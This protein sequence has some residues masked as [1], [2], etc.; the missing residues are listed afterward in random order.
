LDVSKQP[1]MDALR[2]LA[3]DG[4]VEII[5]QVGCRIP[6][7]E[8]QDVTDFFAVF[9]GQSG[10]GK[11]GRSDIG[12]ITPSGEGVGASRRSCPPTPGSGVQGSGGEVSPGRRGVVT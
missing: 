4:L 9:G 3:S 1:I 11:D 2:R 5:P 10:V 12:D 7:H 6:V 8:P